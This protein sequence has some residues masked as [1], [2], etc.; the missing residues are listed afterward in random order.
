[1]PHDQA[2]RQGEIS[3]LAFE[4]LG[5][6]AAIVFLNTDNAL[7]GARPLTLA[8]QSSAGQQRVEAEL[9]RLRNG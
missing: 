9:I 5:K 8:T 7:L 6:D 1:M 4:T 3:R 2:A